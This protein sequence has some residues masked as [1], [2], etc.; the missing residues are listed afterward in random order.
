MKIPRCQVMRAVEACLNEGARK[1]VVY[2]DE[3]TTIKVSR[4]FPKDGRNT[5]TSLMLSFGSPSYEERQFIKLC[6]KAGQ[7]F[8]VRKIQL[9]WYKPKKK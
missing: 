1:A 7:P 6:K 8:P 9:K 5:R 2:L 3:K 4:M